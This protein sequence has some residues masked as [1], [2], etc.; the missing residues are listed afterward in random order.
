MMFA[1][2]S[3][4][5]YDLLVGRT[6]CLCVLSTL[7]GKLR[8]FRKTHVKNRFELQQTLLL[9]K[10]LQGYFKVMLRF[11][12]SIQASISSVLQNACGV[13]FSFTLLRFGLRTWTELR[14]GATTVEPGEGA[15][16]TPSPVLLRAPKM[17][18]A[19]GTTKIWIF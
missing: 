17:A 10:K 5:I 12:Y 16:Y 14:S 13:T 15:S 3:A 7:V 11:L 6:F 8:L 9:R 1:P 18:S 4:R 2:S 19:A